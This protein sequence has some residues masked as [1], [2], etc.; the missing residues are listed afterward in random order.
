M[1]QRYANLMKPLKIRNLVLKNRLWSGNALPHFLQGPESW[2]SEQ[3]INH[4]VRCAKNG[5]AV[6]TFADWTNPNQR[7]AFNED[8]RRFPMYDIND[9]SL[10]NYLCQ[11]TNQIHYYNSFASIAIMPMDYIEGYDVSAREI[12]PQ[13]GGGK[14]LN[15]IN[16]EPEKLGTIH[17]RRTAGG[18]ALKEM[19]HEMIRGLIEREAQR[20]YYYKTMGF[21]M[22]T[23]HFAYN[24]NLF[25][26]F[27]S[28]LGNTRTDEYGGSVEKRCR[29][30][31]EL[32]VRIRELCGKNWPIEVQISGSEVNGNTIEDVCQIA[33]IVEDYV[34]VFQIRDG[35][36]NNSHPVG[37]NSVE[38]D[39]LTLKYSAAIKASGSKILCNPIGGYQMLDEAD[40]MI[41]EGKAD[42]MGAARAFICDFDYYKKALEGRGEDVVPC[43]RCNKCHVPSIE[44]EWLSFC[45]VNPEMGIAH[46]LDF[47]TTPVEGKKKVAV[48]GG[49]PTGLR[50]AI[51][52][53]DR[54]HDVTIYEK[55]DYLGGQLKHADYFKFKWPLRRYRLWMIAQVEKRANI[56]VLLNT[57]ATPELL[58]GENYDVA[59]VA[60]GAVPKMPPVKGIEKA[61]DHFAVWGKHDQLGEKV[62]VIGGSESGCETAMYLAEE[63]VDTTVLTRSNALAPDTTPIHYR[64]DFTNYHTKLDKFHAYKEV[65]TTEVGDGWVKFVDK[66]GV[67]HTIECDTVVA[68]GGMKPLQDEA[69][70][71]YGSADRIIMMGDC[72]NPGNIQR[73][74]RDAYAAAHQ[75]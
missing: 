4:M 35:S 54:G 42:I 67:E 52:A 47:L 11:M 53:A 59:L 24:Q 39:Y 34:D 8:G 26:R 29:F 14:T 7:T 58:K 43:V 37:Y 17:F 48:V 46:K 30:L 5:A 50:A 1:S 49:G 28:P 6:V 27:I 74:N 56:K 3:V 10:Q 45:T 65:T 38:H 21:D 23:L 15:F 19:T 40:A 66:D 62:V 32:C 64:Q 73:C 22:C 41:G 25:A 72:R 75:I 68:L 18:V 71:F 16:D 13:K 36:A 2:P 70:A 9:P 69:M 55:T 61:I 57:E 12:P 31:I 51:Y 44:D 63:G 20:I 60:V 33:K